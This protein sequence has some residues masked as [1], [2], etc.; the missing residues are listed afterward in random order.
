MYQLYCAPNTYAMGAHVLLEELAVDYELK[1]VDLFS[2]SPDPEFLAVSP[3]ARVPALRHS[4]GTIFE[5]GAIALYLTDKHPDKGFGVD[6]DHPDRGRYLQWLYYLSSTVQ[7]EVLIQFH[8]ENYFADGAL[9]LKLKQASMG[10][11]NT[12]WEILNDAYKNGPWLI[13]NRPTAVDYCV[14]IQIGWPECF[15]RNVDQYPHLARMLATISKR[16]AF[17]RVLDWHRDNA[18]M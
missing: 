13:D 11:L 17:S 8:P 14:A 9:Q 1:P 10:R 16:E 12:I 2:A 3:H 6:M 4:Q 18:E 5:S 7:P 15:E